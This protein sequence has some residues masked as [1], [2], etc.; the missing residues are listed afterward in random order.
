MKTNTTYVTKDQLISAYVSKFAFSE[1][2]EEVRDFRE[3]T[4][5]RFDSIDSRLNAHDKRF[6]TID[7]KLDNIEEN[8]RR[9]IG[10][11][12]DQFRADLK[13]GIE[14]IADI[15]EGTRKRSEPL[16]F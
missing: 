3:E 8:T 15:A 10:A 7:R 11:A 13:V 4:T 1:F 16:I 14:Y 6:D 12:L 2:K 5:E 9:T